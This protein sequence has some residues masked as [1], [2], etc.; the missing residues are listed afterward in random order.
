[1][2]NFAPRLYPD[3]NK[4]LEYDLNFFFPLLPPFSPATYRP[5]RGKA[6]L[7]AARQAL[8]Q[9]NDAK[10]PR[11]LG[12]VIFTLNNA[13]SAVG[14]SVCGRRRTP[15]RLGPP[16]E[17]SGNNPVNILMTPDN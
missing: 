17:K 13:M 1:L 6:V 2:P 14:N 7:P 10:E 8:P 11:I 3:G 9:I 16:G 4:R 15:P 5:S 12:A